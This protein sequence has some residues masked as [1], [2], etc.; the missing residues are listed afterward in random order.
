MLRLVAKS[1]IWS[2]CERKITDLINPG[3]SFTCVGRSARNYLNDW[4]RD[5]SAQNTGKTRDLTTPGSPDVAKSATEIFLCTHAVCCT[6]DDLAYNCKI[7]A[8]NNGQN[9]DVGHDVADDLTG[10]FSSDSNRGATK[11]SDS[12]FV[13]FLASTP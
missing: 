6:W 7:G 11:L 1:K 5:V 4:G 2:S 3:R 8:M 13:S 9:Y 10:A 12:V